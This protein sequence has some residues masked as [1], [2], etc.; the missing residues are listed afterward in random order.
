MP[1][2]ESR[3]PNHALAALREEAGLSQQDLGNELNNLAATKHGKHPMITRKTVGRWERGDVSW[4]QPF[5]RRLLGEYFGVSV[6]ELGF[7][8][9]HRT[10]PPQSETGAEPL[11]LAVAP[12]VAEP[13]VEQDRQRWREVR[14]ALGRHRRELAV[15][16]ET[17][18][19]DARVTGLLGT[20]VIST[21]NWL[22]DRPVPLER[23]TL[24]LDSAV[25]EPAIS[26]AEPESAATRPLADANARF[27]CYHDA[28]RDLAAPALFE[29][30]L[31]FRLVGVDWTRPVLSFG[32]MG[33]FDAVDINESVAHELAVHHLARGGDAETVMSRASWRRLRYRK[34]IGDPFDLTRRPLMGAIGTLTIRGGESPSVVLHERDGSRVAGGGG[35]IHLL[36]AGI[37]QPSSVIPA[38]I[39]QDFSIWRS[40]QREYAEELLGHNDPDRR[41]HRPG[42]VRRPVHRRRRDQRRRLSPDH[43]SPFRGEHA[44]LAAGITATVSRRGRGAA[45]RMA[46]PRCSAEGPSPSERITPRA[47][48][49][50]VTGCGPGTACG[51]NTSRPGRRARTSACRTPPPG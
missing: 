28:I 3:V 13:F 36:P 10:R 26:G 43:G 24:E 32:Q 47:P 31:C 18:Y 5:Y 6:D 42:R 25:A 1:A 30:R 40:I 21:P 49:A 29:N 12:F 37:F 50:A 33:F 46:T 8:R 22:P 4:P 39:A 34:L 7:R 23:I 9:P 41:R 14:A 20:G 45:S 44:P 11:S 2:V 16:A 27:R 17:L 48:S 15:L 38:A 51:R 35:M 19:R